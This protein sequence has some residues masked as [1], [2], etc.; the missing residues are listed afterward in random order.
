MIS[1]TIQQKDGIN[2]ERNALIK[3]Y[4]ESQVLTIMVSEIKRINQDI[5]VT[6]FH[7]ESNIVF[8]ALSLNSMRDVML[9]PVL[10][11]IV[12]EKA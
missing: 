3:Q 4:L 2:T 11:P 12:E 9:L 5:C 8:A 6:D 7:H 1:G 10:R